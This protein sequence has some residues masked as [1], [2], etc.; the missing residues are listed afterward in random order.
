MTELS[1]GGFNCLVA[2]SAVSNDSESLL[3]HV[4]Y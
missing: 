3:Y 1:I 2:S 4:Q